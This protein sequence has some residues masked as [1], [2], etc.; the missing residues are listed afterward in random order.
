LGQ[1]AI[2]CTEEDILVACLAFEW[3]TR[4]S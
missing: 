4:F 3:Y 1:E 2:L